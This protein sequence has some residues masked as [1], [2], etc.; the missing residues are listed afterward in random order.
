MDWDS[1]FYFSDTISQTIHLLFWPRFCIFVKAFRVFGKSKFVFPGR[2]RAIASAG[3]DCAALMKKIFKKIIDV[4]I[5]AWL[6]LIMPAF[7]PHFYAAIITFLSQERAWDLSSTGSTG[8]MVALEITSDAPVLIP[9]AANKLALLCCDRILTGV[10]LI[11]GRAMQFDED[12]VFAEIAGYTLRNDLHYNIPTITYR[13]PVSIHAS[14][15]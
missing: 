6:I 9:K 12:K 10:R 4:A 14:E 5:V 2:L 8:E 3:R 1:H 7:T 13:Q 15:G 11:I